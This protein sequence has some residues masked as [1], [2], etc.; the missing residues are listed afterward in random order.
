MCNTTKHKIA[1]AL[2]QLMA[3]RPFQKITV[4]NL[5]DATGMKRQSF[6]YH[7][8]DTRDVLMWICQQELMEPLLASDLDFARWLGYGL[9]LIDR[10]RVF[11]RR[12]LAAARSEF[13]REFNAAVMRPRI[14]RLLF[15]TDQGL[16]E[17]QLFAVEFAA[18]SVTCQLCEFADSR[19]PLEPEILS[20]RIG[21]VLELLRIGG[22][23]RD[24]A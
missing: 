6:Y 20:E 12:M 18:K 11:Y 24:K 22:D 7:F 16:N 13:V 23:I 21:Y 5:M 15:G 10:D 1:G 3:E 17:N 14:A 19:R 4:Q 2:R 8:Q 9:K